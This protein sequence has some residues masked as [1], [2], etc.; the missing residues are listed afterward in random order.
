MSF[1]LLNQNLLFNSQ[2]GKLLNLTSL[3]ET[4]LR[5]N[6]WKLLS[7]F[8]EHAGSDLTSAFILE[9]I[10]E[11]TR[12]KSSVATAVK[13]LRAQLGD[14]SEQPKFIQTQVMKGYAYIGETQALTEAESQSLITRYASLWSKSTNWVQHNKT[15]FIHS[16]IRFTCVLFIAW[17]LADLY[18]NSAFSRLTTEPT[19]APP[20]PMLIHQKAQSP[21]EHDVQICQSLLIEAQQSALF[22]TLPFH[23]KNS[24]PALPRLYWRDHNKEVLVCH[25]SPLK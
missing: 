16:L 23:R 5:S 1:Y 15:F 6:E 7:L 11:S 12:A 9:A 10:W 14:S 17:N 21:S 24:A 19:I 25:L 4:Q 18:N 13:N 3:Q 2:S 22:D 8:I 20:I